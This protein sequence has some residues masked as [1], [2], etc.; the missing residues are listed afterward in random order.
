M[1]CEFSRTDVKQAADL[2]SSSTKAV[3]LTGAG[4]STPSGI[5]DFRSSGSGLWEKYNPFEVASI[6]AF[7][8]DPEK[9]F[10]WSR[11]LL[12]TILE[13]EPNDAH[14]ALAQL[15]QA[16]YLAGIVTQNIDNLH[17]KA[18][19]ENVL[20]VHG[21]LR[22]ATCISCFHKVHTEGILQNYVSS[23]EIP[24]CENCGS[25]L[26]PDII[27]F[28]EQLPM[29]VVLKAKNLMNTSD[30]IMVIGSSLEVTPVAV[31]PVA[32][33]NAGG[34]LII[35]NQEP[36]YLDGRAE[37]IFSCNAADVLPEI[38]FEVLHGRN[39]RNTTS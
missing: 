34:K 37:I 20:E 2:I 24:T 39:R 21:H 18:G 35:I 10:N 14:I 36:T 7:R 32:P 25:I 3:A 29:D 31:F 6:T 1:T 4:I 30:L 16:G 13:A 11:P 28:G 17:H 27:L 12:N 26:K 5:P 15:E 9:F 23:T 8:Y 19:S 38:A 22:E 33:L